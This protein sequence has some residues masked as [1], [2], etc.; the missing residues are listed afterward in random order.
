[1]LLQNKKYMIGMKAGTSLT[2][3]EEFFTIQKKVVIKYAYKGAENSDKF[4]CGG[5]KYI[6]EALPQ[7]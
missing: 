2:M 4:V 5:R 3:V 6:L 7:T 1:M